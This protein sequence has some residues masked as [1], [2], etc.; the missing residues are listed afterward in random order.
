LN[1]K[2]EAV[3][4]DHVHGTEYRCGFVPEGET[5]SLKH[6]TEVY[7]TT[8]S[9]FTY[10]SDDEHRGMRLALCARYENH[11]GGKGPWGPIIVVYIP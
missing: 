8:K 11:R 2:Q 4:P 7:F 10:V 5:P 1:E 6:L 9:S 3:K